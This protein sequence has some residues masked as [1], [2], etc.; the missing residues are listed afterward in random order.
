MKGIEYVAEVYIGTVGQLLYYQ[1]RDGKKVYMET[2]NGEYI[3]FLPKN[4]KIALGKKIGDNT[5]VNDFLSIFK[6][7]GLLV[8]DSDKE[9][10]TYTQRINGKPRKV[11]T[12]KKKTYEE[13]VRLSKWTVNMD[14]KAGS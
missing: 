7:L 12:I 13:L 2:N 14:G 9:R 10:F 11:I 5:K 1:G 6:N 4:F 8:T 3:N